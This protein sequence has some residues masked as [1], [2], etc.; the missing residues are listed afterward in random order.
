M[1]VGLGRKRKGP[2]NWTELGWWRGP[3]SQCCRC[4]WG[5]VQAGVSQ[6]WGWKACRDRPRVS[7]GRQPGPSRGRPPPGRTARRPGPAAGAAP[8]P[9]LPAACPPHEQRRRSG[10]TPGSPARTRRTWGAGSRHG[11]PPR[12]G[13]CV[14]RELGPHA[15]RPALPPRP[16]GPQGP[17]AVRVT[18]RLSLPPPGGHEGV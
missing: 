7:P 11:S 17:G 10:G 16:E 5:G 1:R 18:G 2:D 15:H 9:A 3:E 14:P 8:H 6:S 12:P 4:H 13:P